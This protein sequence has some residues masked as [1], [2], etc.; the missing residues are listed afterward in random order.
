MTEAEDIG[1]RRL[2][3]IV[4]ITGLGLGTVFLLG[5]GAGFIAAHV[6]DGDP[7]GLVG[8]LVLAG[9]VLALAACAWLLLREVRKPTGEEPLTRRERLNRN[10]IVGCG[11]AGLVIGA[12][13]ALGGGVDLTQGGGVFSN[14]PLPPALALVLVGLIGV[15]LPLV[16]IFWHRSAV[17]ELEAD[18]YK[19][20]AL[21]AAYVYMIGAPVWWLLWRGGFVPEPDGIT[22]YF[23]VIFTLG[24]VWLRKKHG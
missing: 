17:D 6:E 21:Y 18:A 9:I 14:G 2:W 13:L 16:S 8:A 10:I 11:L 7:F 23:A 22:I 20:G 24:I 3:R 1:S 12:A 19:T 15:V 5:M 4:R